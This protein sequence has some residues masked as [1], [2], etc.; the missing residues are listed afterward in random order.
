MGSPR[1]G[2]RA[3]R[4][5][6]REVVLEDGAAVEPASHTVDDLGVVITFHGQDDVGNTAAPAH[7]A[8]LVGHWCGFWCD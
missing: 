3:S 1:C 7:L 5:V 6:L 2:T 8:E 4:V